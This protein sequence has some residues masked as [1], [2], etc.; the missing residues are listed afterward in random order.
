MTQGDFLLKMG[1]LE[2][3]GRLGAA[4]DEAARNAIRD[5]VE[6]LAGP[7][8]MGTLFKALCITPAGR[9]PFP[10]ASLD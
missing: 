1:L 4:A 6:R 5:A 7:D 8:G 10:F 9:M 3:A 2:R